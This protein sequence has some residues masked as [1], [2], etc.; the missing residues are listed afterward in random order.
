MTYTTLGTLG[1]VLAAIATLAVLFRLPVRSLRSP[2]ICPHCGCSQPL[3][4]PPSVAARVVLNAHKCYS[5][6]KPMEREHG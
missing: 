4:S 3:F 5:C 6:G 1:L 2:A